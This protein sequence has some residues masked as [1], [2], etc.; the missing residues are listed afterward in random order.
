MELQ[1][2]WFLMLLIFIAGIYYL[3]N[4]RK[5]EMRQKVVAEQIK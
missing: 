4:Q 2:K 5:E 1:M 3:V